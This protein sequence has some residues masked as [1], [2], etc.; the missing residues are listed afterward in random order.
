MKQNVL[1]YV[2]VC[3][4]KA[5]DVGTGYG[6]YGV[7][8]QQTLQDGTMNGRMRGERELVTLGRILLPT[9]SLDSLSE[10]FLKFLYIV[11]IILTSI[12]LYRATHGRP[13]RA[14]GGILGE[15]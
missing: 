7:Q 1:R 10:L 8:Q 12:C 2:C 5:T 11:L 13:R 9:F 14:M 15:S 3:I 4:Y 6:S